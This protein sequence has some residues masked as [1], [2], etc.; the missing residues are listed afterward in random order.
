MPN[1]REIIKKSARATIPTSDGD[2]HIDYYPH[3]ISQRLSLQLDE[4]RHKDPNSIGIDA[5]R[6]MN[7]LIINLI[8]DWDMMD[9]DKKYPLDPDAWIDLSIPVVQE[10]IGAI[11][12]PK[13]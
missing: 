3:K 11:I 9:G 13:N 2:L 12:A 10:I 8:E 7:T 4:F 1:Y 6:E 5:F